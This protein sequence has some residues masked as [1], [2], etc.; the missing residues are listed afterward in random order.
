[1]SLL[2]SILETI[3]GKVHFVIT[4]GNKPAI[5][6]KLHDKEITV[7]IKN[8]ILAIEFG[9]EE[10]LEHMPSDKGSGKGKQESPESMLKKL[11]SMGYTIKVK[12]KI[13]EL[14]L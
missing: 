11:K 3:F 13:F 7:D 6:I 2:E 1:M 14:D 5:E 4:V 8:P 12:Y 9:L 10:L